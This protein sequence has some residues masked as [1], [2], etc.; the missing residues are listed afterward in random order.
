[1]ATYKSMWPPRGAKKMKGIRFQTELKRHRIKVTV[2]VLA[3][4]SMAAVEQ[5]DVT[6]PRKRPNAS[7]NTAQ[8]ARERKT[9]FKVGFKK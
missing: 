8:C 6:L 2:V 7:I 5:L 4:T 1:M 3:S 9:E